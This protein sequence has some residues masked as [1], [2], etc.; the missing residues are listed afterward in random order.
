M[1]VGDL[2]A[3]QVPIP[4]TAAKVTGPAPGP[5]TK[6]YVQMVGRMAYYWG[7]P[8]G[9][10]ACVL[11]VLG[12]YL[13]LLPPALGFKALQVQGAV[14]LLALAAISVYVLLLVQRWPASFTKNSCSN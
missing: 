4:Q 6:E 1:L 3:Q 9:V 14:N 10:V 12:V 5:M 8:L 7:W 11:Q 2:H 13:V